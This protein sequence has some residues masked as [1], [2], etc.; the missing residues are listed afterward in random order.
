MQNVR[1]SLN[2]QKMAALSIVCF[3]RW[4]P[5]TYLFLLIY[6]NYITENNWQET[7]ETI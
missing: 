5:L 7:F 6:K 2:S 1:I 4:R 3:Y